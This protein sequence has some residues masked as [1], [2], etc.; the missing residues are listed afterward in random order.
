MKM[1][2]VYPIILTPSQVGYVVTVPDLNINT[3]GSDI[4]DAIFKA[5]DAIGM[6]VINEQDDGRDVSE[7]STTEPVHKNN[8][9]VSWVDVD[10]DQYREKK[11]MSTIY[12]LD[13]IAEVI[14]PI[15]EKYAITAVYIFGSYARGE[16]RENSD[17]D[18]LVDY[19]E[20]NPPSL[21]DLSTFRADCSEAL[22][23]DVD[24]VTVNALKYN[25]NP[26]FTKNVLEERTFI[27][28]SIGS[29]LADSV[30]CSVTEG[31]AREG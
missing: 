25:K 10:F 23:K 9:L 27:F 30:S 4:L 3:H 12:T 8:E 26:K 6:W 21:W 11:K 20:E 17:V 16:A 18:L 1:V 2:K 31:A 22:G 5:R 7:P 29:T 24:S 28:G 15:A 14:T 19:S 13:E